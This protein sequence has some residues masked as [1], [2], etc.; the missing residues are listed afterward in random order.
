MLIELL[1]NYEIGR[2]MRI[3]LSQ[4]REELL[5]SRYEYVDM[6]SERQMSILNTTFKQFILLL[7]SLGLTPI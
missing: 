6:N 5:S 1:R 2:R 3:L 7:M 4:A